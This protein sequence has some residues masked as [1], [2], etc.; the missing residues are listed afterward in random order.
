[1]TRSTLVM[2]PSILAV[3]APTKLP[4]KA[5]WGADASATRARRSELELASV[6]TA[7]TFFQASGV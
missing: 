5:S 4:A 3:V 6:A 2:R 7:V 1:M